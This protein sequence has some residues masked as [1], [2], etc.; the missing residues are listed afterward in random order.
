MKYSLYP[1]LLLTLVLSACGGG[2]GGSTD[3]APNTNAQSSGGAST[4]LLASS[5]QTID[6]Y[7]DSTIWGLKS[8]TTNTQVATPAPTAFAQALAGTA[9]HT[10]NNKGVNGSTACDLWNGNTGLGM[11]NWTTEMASSKATV[12]IINDAINDSNPGTGESVAQYSTCL[13]NLA[14]TAKARGKKVIF[15]TPNPVDNTGLDAYV[16]AMKNVASSKSIPVI[17]EYTYLRNQLTDTYTI[18]DMDPDGT[19]PNDN[20]YIQKGQ[21][22]ANVFKQ[23]QNNF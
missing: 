4:Q 8:G 16:T 6:Y 11:N 22:A 9:Q 1:S 2:G 3:T 20:V 13:S 23:L 19:H 10:I 18:R 17:D 5:G 15:E 14:D 21:F 12:V 7:G